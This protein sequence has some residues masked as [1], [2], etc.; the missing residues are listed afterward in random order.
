MLVWKSGNSRNFVNPGILVLGEGA[1][2]ADNSLPHLGTATFPTECRPH[3]TFPFVPIE[4]CGVFG[5]FQIEQGMPPNPNK[6]IFFRAVVQNLHKTVC[7]THRN[8]LI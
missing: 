4:F 8:D 2:K 7:A 5:W 1:Q 6:H 3:I